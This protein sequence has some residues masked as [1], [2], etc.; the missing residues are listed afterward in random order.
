[1]TFRPS[2]ELLEDINSNQDSSVV[3]YNQSVNSS[4]SDADI[5]QQIFDQSIVSDAWENE[6]NV[7]LWNNSNSYV[8]EI[9]APDLSELLEKNPG[10]KVWN[11]VGKDVWMQNWV[12]E[13]LNNV[14]NL[15]N[16][17]NANVLESVENNDNIKNVE[18]WK[19]NN[20]VKNNNVVIETDSSVGNSVSDDYR[21]EIVSRVN[22]LHSNL[23]LLVDDEWYNIVEKYKKI[24]RIVF[25]WGIY[26]LFLVLWWVLWIVA[27]VYA[28]QPKTSYIINDSSIQSKNSWREDT[29]DKV[30]SDLANNESLDIKIITPYGFAWVEGK[31]L[32]SKSNLVSYEWI[33]L[34]QMA[35][36]D[37]EWYDFISLEK[38][39]NGETTREDLEKMV[40]YLITDDL[41]YNKTASLPKV[42]DTRWRWQTF[43]VGLVEWFNLSCVDNTK[44]SGLVCD[45]FL[46]IFYDYGKYYDLSRYSSE[47]LILVRELRNQNK[48]IEPI[49]KMINEY[50]L[51][52]W[53]TSS[54]FNSIMSNCN[55]E[56]RSFYENLVNFI[57]DENS[58]TIEPTRIFENSD[59]NAYKLLSLQQIVYRNLDTSSVNEELIKSYLTFVQNLINKDRWSNHYLASIYKDILY[60]FN[61]DILEQKLVQKWKLSSEIRKQLDQINNGNQLMDYLSLTSQLTTTGVINLSWEFITTEFSEKTVDEIFSQY[62]S[63]TEHLKIRRKIQLSD[64][65]IQVQAELY[66]SDILKVTWWETLKATVIL[67][68][69]G[70]ALYVSSISIS[71]QPDLSNML[72]IYV[73]EWDVGLNAV[74]WYIGEKIWFWYKDTQWEPVVKATL[75]EVLQDRQDIDLYTCNDTSVVLY[76][77]D[78]E[79]TF[80][81]LNGVLESFSV[82]DTDLN[83]LVKERF[84][85][86]LSPRD[87]TLTLIESIINFKKDD[88]TQ[89]DNI[90]K[91]LEII[92][93]FR[94]NLKVVPTISEID[95]EENIFLVDFLLWDF[96]LQA[97]YDL[98]NR[99]LTQISYVACWN[100]LEIDGFEIR[101]SK[102]NDSQL[103]QMI[104]NPKVFLLNVNEEAYKKYQRMCWG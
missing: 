14:W 18:N 12:I 62:Y 7:V 74:L 66:S 38:F 87:A 43:D 31:I 49:C 15:D 34:P 103:N 91:K 72:N 77:W 5:W 13:N 67:H 51:H 97:R 33:I 75:C 93:Q 44:V 29:S 80:V 2:D 23:D 68:K 10:I 55:W 104:N 21:R 42:S 59:L 22:G 50:V 101:L 52:S 47:L 95:G 30:F 94:I 61:T 48:D 4:D 11:D 69:N 36:I 35:Y 3:N 73:S 41:I 96:E 37:S 71:N 86:I 46:N 88:P 65:D 84:W 89:N 24:H 82:S 99:L 85:G 40:K 53:E 92:D 8:E 57:N 20:E 27:Q 32:R 70:N 6:S 54:I 19:L 90:E 83:S 16:S 28:N 79:Y 102:D 58:L 45:K 98:S 81:L 60:V 100:I 78:F 26:I 56:L 76:K 63:M 17:N 25:R 39:T 9:K 64:T 1:M